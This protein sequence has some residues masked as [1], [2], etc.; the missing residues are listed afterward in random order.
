MMGIRD[1]VLKHIDRLPQRK[2]LRD[3]DISRWV[4]YVMASQPDNAIWLVSRLGTIGGSEIGVLVQSR[5]NLE[6]EYISDIGFAH[7]TDLDVINSKMLKTLPMMP[8]GDMKRGTMFEFAAAAAT[9]SYLKGI[10]VDGATVKR[11]PDI[12]EAIL[13]AADSSLYWARVQV[14]DVYE[15]DGKLIVVDYKCPTEK[16]LVSLLNLE[17]VMYSAQVTI[18]KMIGKEIGIKIDELYVL[19]LDIK[20]MEVVP[21]P[22]EIDAEFELE[23]REVGE[24]YFDLF[25]NGRLPPPAFPKYSINDPSDL[26]RGLA[27]NIHRESVL[28]LAAKAIENELMILANP[29]QKGLQ[30]LRDGVD[31]SQPFKF[32][33]GCMNLT[34]ALKKSF[35]KGSVAK[36]KHALKVVGAAKKDLETL[37]DE[38]Y[39][40]SLI[41]NRDPGGDR[42]KLREAALEDLTET[43]RGIVEDVSANLYEYSMMYDSPD[44]ISKAQTRQLSTLKTIIEH[45]PTE[46]VAQKA[47]DAYKSRSKLYS[48]TLVEKQVVQVSEPQKGSTIERR[49]KDSFIDPELDINQLITFH[50]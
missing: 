14:D 44:K 46:K 25:T 9:L 37:Y 18:A 38:D 24:Y 1:E 47:T 39:E 28:R 19:P 45:S 48:S 36:I 26:P 30:Q 31:E 21:M 49:S 10:A 7:S 3:D 33:V 8:N 11:R 32:N 2:Y 50:I 43:V 13:N 12:T 27:A 23:I 4:D 22:V 16:G 6:A 5:R 34:G 35:N 40:V 20:T 41:M 17:P 15:I 29:V 42:K